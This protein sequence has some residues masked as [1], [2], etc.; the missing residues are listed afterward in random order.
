MSANRLMGYDTSR[1]IS[2]PKAT[3]ASASIST[4]GISLPRRWGGAV[5]VTAEVIRV[6]GRTVTFRVEARAGAVAAQSAI[7]AEQ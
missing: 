3:R 2:C 7:S 4:S 5:I 6:A 1:L